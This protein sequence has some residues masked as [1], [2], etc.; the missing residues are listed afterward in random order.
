[1]LLD[2]RGT[3]LSVNEAWRQFATDNSLPGPRSG[4]GV[5][6]LEVC[7]GASGAGSAQAAQAANGIRAVLGGAKDFS[8]EYPCHS[9]MERRWF[10]M[11]V[12]P[13][14]GSAVRGA[15]VMHLNITERKLAEAAQ[16]ASKKRLRYL[17]DGLGASMMVGLMTPEGILVEANAPALAAVGLSPEDV[18]GRP[19]VDSPWFAHSTEVQ[20]QLRDAIVRGLRGEA[21]RY[22]M[23]I[24][25]VGGLLID[26]D[27]VLNPVRDEAG[28]IVFLVPS[29]SVITE[30]KRAE[31]AMRESNEKFHQLAD[32]LTDAFWI[33]S[34][35]MS[36]VQYVSP[37][38]EKIWGRTVKSL[39]ENPHKWSEFILAEDRAR[40]LA[41]FAGLSPLAPSL[42]IEYRIVRPG[43]EIRWVR[44]RGSQIRDSSDHL[45]RHIGIVSDITDRKHVETELQWKTAFLEAQVASSI[46]GILV[47]D[48]QGRKLLTTQERAT[49]S[50]SPRNWRGTTRMR[51]SSGG[52]PSG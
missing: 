5:N 17:I 47:V 27:F 4:P 30:R 8:F 1:A 36:E 13:L 45:L 14:F 10:L 40:V 11:T 34:P 39:Q 9:P 19:L 29:G 44:V 52:W 20:Q 33:R 28:K 2:A 48:E 21:S 51:R 50:T 31:T 18:L 22:D 42:D 12:T 23:K 35:D 6:Y 15:V 46:D 32:N 7:D 49:C 43:G 37:A 24:R 26:V 25:G 3:I 41:A 38:F 16:G